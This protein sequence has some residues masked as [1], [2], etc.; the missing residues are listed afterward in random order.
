MHQILDERV[1]VHRDLERDDFDLILRAKE[2]HV[3]IMKSSAL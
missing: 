1:D 3:Q 2:K